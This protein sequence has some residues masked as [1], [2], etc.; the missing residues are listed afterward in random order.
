M[1]MQLEYQTESFLARQVM[2]GLTS[3][4]VTLDST[5]RVG[6]ATASA[7]CEGICENEPLVDGACCVSYA[8]ITKLQV[9][10][11][12]AIGTLL[13]SNASGFG[14]TTDGTTLA[15]N[16]RAVLLETTIDATSLAMVRLIDR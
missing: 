11:A 7:A 15:D 2:T 14:I 9:G 1:A 3:R 8:G 16:A 10:G 12:Y 6:L 5:G 13:R 4:F